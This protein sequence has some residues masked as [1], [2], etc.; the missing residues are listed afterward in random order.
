MGLERW[1][2]DPAVTLLANETMELTE[3]YGVGVV[4]YRVL[5]DAGE[6]LREGKV[7]P[8]LERAA[9]QPNS[10]HSEQP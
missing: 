7:A 6:V 5:N 9:D 8:A 2:F 1:L 4:K 10:P 3:V